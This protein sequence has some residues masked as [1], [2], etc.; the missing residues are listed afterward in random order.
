MV[1]N[2]C[3]NKIKEVDSYCPNCGAVVPNGQPSN[4][5]RRERGEFEERVWFRFLKVLYVVIYLVVIGGIIIIGFSVMPHRT[6]DG[7]SSTVTCDNG[8]IYPL[9][10]NNIFAY[11]NPLDSDSDKDARILCQYDTTNYFGSYYN[12]YIAPNYTFNPVYNEPDYGGWFWGFL[13]G[14]LIG[15]ITLKMVK[16]G[17]LYIAT[18]SKPQW[19][20]ELKRIF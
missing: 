18:G 17:V 16:V 11:S 8:N 14:L 6:L 1:C 10:K 2:N 12:Q 5:P 9:S 7:A 3:G 13:I 20:K 4:V 19:A 15:L